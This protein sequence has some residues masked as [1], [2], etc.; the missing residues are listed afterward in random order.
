ML[1][2]Y[3]ASQEQSDLRTLTAA[4]DEVCRPRGLVTNKVL[5]QQAEGVWVF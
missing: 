2:S 1:Q 4:Y 5:E 3:G